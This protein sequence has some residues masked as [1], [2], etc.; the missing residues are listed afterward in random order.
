LGLF[1]INRLNN[2]FIWYQFEY[3]TD[4]TTEVRRI[5]K[6]C[7]PSVSGY[8]VRS[9]LGTLSVR[10]ATEQ[11]EAERERVIKERRMSARMVGISNF[12]R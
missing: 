5:L 2:A 10:K 8:A 4:G 3:V 12:I 7:T 6:P 1:G 9:M 11:F